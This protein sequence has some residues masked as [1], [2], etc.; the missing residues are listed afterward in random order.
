MFDELLDSQDTG[1]TKKKSLTLTVSIII[2]AVLLVFAIILPLLFP[3]TLSGS[4]QQLTFLVAPPP[5]PP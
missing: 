1:H 5:P 4:I 2:H 3:D